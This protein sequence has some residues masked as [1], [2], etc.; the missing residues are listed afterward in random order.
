M[1]VSATGIENPEPILRIDAP[2]FNSPW[3]QAA[4]PRKPVWRYLAVVGALVLLGLFSTASWKMWSEIRSRNPQR[5][6]ATQA[7][8]AM[9]DIEPQSPQYGSANKPTPEQITPEVGPTINPQKNRVVQAAKIE[10]EPDDGLIRIIPT[11]SSARS[12]VNGPAPVAKQAESDASA[13]TPP[14]VAMVS[15][16]DDALHGLL[17]NAT[18]LPRLN[19]EVSQGVIPVVLEHKVMPSYPHDALVI[20]REGV[21]V[22]RAIVTDNGRVSQMKL[23]SGDPI[24]GRAAMDAVRQWRYRPAVLNGKPTQSETNITLNFK[25]P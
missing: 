10:D 21:V 20:H 7:P 1:D 9:T 5:A 24:L 13:N 22:M 2:V 3:A 19:P 23:I 15:T 11:N 12:E 14:E 25:L 17:S 8:R 4:P 18:T 16:P 6:L